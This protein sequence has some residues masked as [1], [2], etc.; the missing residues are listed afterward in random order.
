MQMLWNVMLPWAWNG[1]PWDEEGTYSTTVP[2]EDEAEA[3]LNAAIEMADSGQKTMVGDEDR[4]RYIE[5]RVNGWGDVYPQRDRLSQ[6]LASV[7]EREL[8][9]DGV[10]KTINLEALGL[11]LAVHR[12]EV[13]S[14]CIGKAGSR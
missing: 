10:R 3:K 14:P 6:D 12:A 2:G 11:L 9:P 8:F 4:Q 5:S 1:N 13:L 7:F